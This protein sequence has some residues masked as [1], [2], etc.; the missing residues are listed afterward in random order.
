LSTP[1]ILVVYRAVHR[2][3]SELTSWT[4]ADVD[5]GGRRRRRRQ[6]VVSMIE[7]ISHRRADRR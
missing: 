2:L 3:R 1:I 4:G 6:V 5:A 7:V